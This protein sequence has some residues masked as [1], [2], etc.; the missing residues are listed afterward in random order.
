VLLLNFLSECVELSCR[1]K[2]DICADKK[3]EEELLGQA[4]HIKLISA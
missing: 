2:R 3:D 1:S 4:Y